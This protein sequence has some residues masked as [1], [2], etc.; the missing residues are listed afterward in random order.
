MTE[1]EQLPKLNSATVIIPTFDHGPLLRQSIASVLSQTMTDFEILVIGDGAPE[2]TR[3]IIDEMAVQDSRIRGVWHPK[4]ERLGELYRNEV[5][6]S[7][8]HDFVCYLSDDDLWSPDHLLEMSEVLR[9]TDVAHTNHLFLTA[10]E[11]T[12]VVAVDL[13]DP[14]YRRAHLDGS[15][16]VCL[17]AIG[18]TRSA[19]QKGLRWNL[20]PT[21]RY[22]DWY[23]LTG[24]MEL[25]LSFGAT[26]STTMLNI[27]SSFRKG[28]TLTQRYEEL[29]RWRT[30]VEGPQWPHVVEVTTLRAVRAERR[31]PPIV[32]SGTDDA[33]PNAEPVA[34]PVAEEPPSPV[35]VV[36][37]EPVPEETT[38]MTETTEMA[39]ITEVMADYNAQIAELKAQLARLGSSRT[40]RTLRYVSR[41]RLIRIAA[42]WTHR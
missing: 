23:F 13:G 30:T 34:E 42:R 28:W 7:S 26:N 11:Q 5:I 8:P 21:D 15:S 10:D 19:V 36:E 1:P 38:E 27:A 9:H 6:E 33:P 17:S 14:E 39:E 18:H 29:E 22:T 4:G 40:V 2:S 31:P 37:P 12:H 32:P 35:V 20:T 24:A 16:F 3:E 25:G 41:Y